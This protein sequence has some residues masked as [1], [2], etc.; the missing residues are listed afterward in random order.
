[1]T[2]VVL[3]R[4]QDCNLHMLILPLQ[5]VYV[6]VLV[7]SNKSELILLCHIDV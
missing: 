1:M 7:L 6:S 5:C 4:D 3:H 2:Q